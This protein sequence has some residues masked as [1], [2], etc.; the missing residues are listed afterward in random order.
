MELGSSEC[1]SADDTD[2]EQLATAHCTSA[3]P[4]GGGAHLLW[5][6]LIDWLQKKRHRAEETT[7]ERAAW[8]QLYIYRV[9]VPSGGGSAPATAKADRLAAEETPQSRRNH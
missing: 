7:E 3:Q 2:A 5:R 6:K 9:Y 1:E 8:Q 4:S